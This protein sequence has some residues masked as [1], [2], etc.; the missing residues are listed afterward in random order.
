MR[1]AGF[2]AQNTRSGEVAPILIRARLTS[3]QPEFHLYVEEM[4]RLFLSR[5]PKLLVDGLSAFLIV[6]HDDNTADIYLGNELATISEVRVKRPI[7]A[8][9]VVNTRDIVDV[10]SIR[11]PN[12]TL[13][14][15]DGVFYVAKIGW[16]FGM[17]FDLDRSSPLDI[18]AMAMDLAKTYRELSFEHVYRVLRSGK[19]YQEMLDDGWFPFIEIAA[20][21]YRELARAYADR[22]DFDARV[23]RVVG[24]FTEA[25][26]QEITARWWSDTVFESRR[27][28][29]ESGV[30]S[31]LQGDQHGAIA[32]IKT[33]STEFEGILL[34]VHSRQIG[35]KIKL[36][37]AELLSR[38]AAEEE[39]RAGSPDSLVLPQAFRE[40]ASQAIYG[41]F[42]YEQGDLPLSRHSAGHGVARQET[43]TR[44]KALQLIL[45]IDQLWFFAQRPD[46]G[47]GTPPSATSAAK[48]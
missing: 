20:T 4:T 36:A 43:Y 24:A 45:S 38:I 23:G 29:L 15:T 33:L 21:E 37:P 8:G 19:Q 48:G 3:D 12:V 46:T 47:T 30:R 34:D 28:I 16:K 27:L 31:F 1:V 9:Q 42:D 18:Q 41:K 2:A 40:Y 39:S 5:I 11:F 17:F 10:R 22:F 6:F 7:N 35:S 25:R 32:A 14:P 13:A 44:S 26:L